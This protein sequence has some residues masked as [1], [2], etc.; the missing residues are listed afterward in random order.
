MLDVKKHR[1]DYGAM[2]IPPTGYRLAKA[3]AAT[4]SSAFPRICFPFSPN[5]YFFSVG[6]LG[7]VFGG[8]DSEEF[9]DT[10]LEVG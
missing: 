7:S 4:Y 6:T 8:G 2:L 3:V 9:E 10:A 1:L 5:F